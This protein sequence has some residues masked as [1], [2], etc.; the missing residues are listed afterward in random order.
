MKTL[1]ICLTVFTGFFLT[2]CKEEV[3]LISDYKETAVV[4]GLLDKNDSIHMIR[5]NRAFIGPGNALTFAAEPDSNYFKSVDARIIEKVAGIKTNEWE[6]LDTTIYDKETNGI[7]YAPEQT[8]Y[9]FK[10][11]SLNENA[12]YE[13]HIDIN[14]GQFQISSETNLVK[15]IT[16]EIPN[17]FKFSDGPGE[18]VTSSI[19]VDVGTSYQ[20][21]LTLTLAFHELIEEDTVNRGE[22][23]WKI[24]EQACNPNETIPFSLDG[25]TFYQL[26]K[27][28]TCDNGDPS[29]SERI[30]KGITVTATGAAE[31]FYNYILANQ[32][33]S[34][35]AQSKPTY[36]NLTATGG[37]P[38]IGIFSSRETHRSFHPF[39]HQLLPNLRLIDDNSTEELCE[40]SITTLACKFCSDHPTDNSSGNE[41]S[42]ACPN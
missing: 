35:L 34:S 11:P 13:L 31:E 36:T 16:L 7:F 29:I 32:P 20:I 24:E 5:I 38:V 42:Y 3:N 26:I 19:S 39:I 14:N 18:Y 25:E 40:G 9:Y 12:T 17:T 22:I 41:K 27:N 33:S 8:L 1:L 21:D 30:F 28:A 10:E 37:H 6:L 23:Q 2:S 15:G 4:Y